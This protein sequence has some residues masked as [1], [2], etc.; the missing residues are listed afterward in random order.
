[1]LLERHSHYAGWDRV[2]VKKEIGP[3]RPSK[4]DWL[5]SLASVLNQKDWPAVDGDLGFV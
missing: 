3:P 5:K 4:A 2:P 1:L